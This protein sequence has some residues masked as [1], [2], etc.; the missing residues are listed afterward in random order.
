MA[1]R[2]ID[3]SAWL[4]SCRSGHAAPAGLPAL[5][6]GAVLAT[7]PHPEFKATVFIH[8][9]LRVWR[10]QRSRLHFG[11]GGTTRNTQPESKA[12]MLR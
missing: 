4:S 3:L 9:Q 6:D 7:I 10:D 11:L 1:L 5:G 2:D 12:F 8:S